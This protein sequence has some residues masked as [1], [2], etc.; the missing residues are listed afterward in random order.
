V[1]E[2][3][4]E[5]N[6]KVTA[7]ER[8]MESFFDSEAHTEAYRFFRTYWGLEDDAEGDTYFKWLDSIMFRNEYRRWLT[9]EGLD[10]L[11]SA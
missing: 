7:E 4:E 8:L 5:V 2:R 3:G 6:M 9:T 10:G 1:V 11:L